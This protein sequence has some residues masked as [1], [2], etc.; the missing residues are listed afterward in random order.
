MSFCSGLAAAVAYISEVDVSVMGI[1][2]RSNGCS[3]S[4]NAILRGWA[5]VRTDKILQE[6]MARA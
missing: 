5:C 2:E 6:L 4:T 1:W 3:A